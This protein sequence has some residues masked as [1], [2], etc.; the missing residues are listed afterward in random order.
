MASLQQLARQ[1][2]LV[3]FSLH[4]PRSDIAGMLDYT[5]LMSRGYVLYYGPTSKLVPYFT[6]LGYPCP[7]YANPLD[8]YSKYWRV[9]HCGGRNVIKVPFA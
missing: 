3:M 4:Q 6:Q 2:T 8:T 9:S 1:G 5:A 7:T